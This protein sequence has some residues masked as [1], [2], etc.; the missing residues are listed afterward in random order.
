MFYS[1]L[2]RFSHKMAEV[3]DRKDSSSSEEKED[4]LY[5]LLKEEDLVKFYSKVKDELQ[6]TQLSHFD[7]VQLEDLV[8]IGMGPPAARRLLASVKKMKNA[9]IKKNIIAK[10]VNPVRPLLNNTASLR[11]PSPSRPTSGRRAS[12]G[13]TGSQLT[14]LINEKDI[15]L[16]NKLGDGSFGVVKRGEWTV[17]GSFR[18]Q[19]VTCYVDVIRL[20]SG[21]VCVRSL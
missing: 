11:G 8:K 19:E 3:Q 18:I 20:L 9:I 6:V 17:P 21:C 10:L 16:L 5:T 4:W 13:S 14:C 15:K 2:S 12:V 7:Y 1:L